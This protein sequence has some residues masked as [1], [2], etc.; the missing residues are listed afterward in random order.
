VNEITPLYSLTPH[1]ESR[2]EKVEESERKAVDETLNSGAVLKVAEIQ[3]RN[4]SERQNG[5]GYWL[6]DERLTYHG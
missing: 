6:R 3:A 4:A 1:I 2:K 5:G